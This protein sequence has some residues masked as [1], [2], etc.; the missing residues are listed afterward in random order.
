MFSTDDPDI[1]VTLNEPIDE[2]VYPPPEPRENVKQK[3]SSPA[4]ELASTNS[5]GN[6]PSEEN[7]EIT[8]SSI[9]KKKKHSN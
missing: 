3:K 6:K 1:E 2:I 8:S 5:D 7:I 9:K 4:L